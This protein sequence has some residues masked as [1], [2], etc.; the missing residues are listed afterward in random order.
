[1]TGQGGESLMGPIGIIVLA[2]DQIERGLQAVL[3]IAGG[4]SVAL[5]VMNFL[6]LPALDGGRLIFL[7]YEVAAR[8]RV[9]ARLEAV[10]HWVGLILLLGL[11]AV[12]TLR[13]ILVAAS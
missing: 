4:L 5:A 11:L 12:I 1:V 6:P 2:K 13:D 8:R 7:G 3:Q 9:P 10:V